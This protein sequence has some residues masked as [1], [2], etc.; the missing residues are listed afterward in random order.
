[1]PDIGNDQIA[2]IHRPIWIYS[3]YFETIITWA[4]QYGYCVISAKAVARQ[5][6]H[7]ERSRR[8]IQ[9]GT[10]C[11]IKSGMTVLAYYVA[12]SII[13]QGFSCVIE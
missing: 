2:Q 4:T 9:P 5:A 13:L 10:G 3:F 8:G 6:R 11:R 12:E 7:P 1:L